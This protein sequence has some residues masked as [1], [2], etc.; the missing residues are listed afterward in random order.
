M[1]SAHEVDF[2]RFLCVCE[3]KI[4]VKIRKQLLYAWNKKIKGKLVWLS[5]EI[6]NEVRFVCLFSKLRRAICKRNRR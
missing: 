5:W 1:H 6:K 2:H 3:R 4:T